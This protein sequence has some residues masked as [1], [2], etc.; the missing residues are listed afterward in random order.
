MLQQWRSSLIS[1]VGPTARVVT[2]SRAAITNSQYLCRESLLQSALQTRKQRW[3]PWYQWSL[4][5]LVVMCERYTELKI[6]AE[7]WEKRKPL[8]LQQQY[9]G[10]RFIADFFLPARP[11]VPCLQESGV[12]KERRIYRPLYTNLFFPRSPKLHSVDVK[13]AA[14]PR[15]MDIVSLFTP[16][17][18]ILLLLLKAI[19]F[20]L[21]WQCN[22][23]NCLSLSCSEMIQFAL[24]VIVIV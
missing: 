22:V 24:A 11:F 17:N 19:V 20:V 9:F 8:F 13:A 4:L 6:Q 23:W 15:G 1:M 16:V 2:S 14:W 21:T 7:E 12:S 3:A 5:V 10:S 18:M